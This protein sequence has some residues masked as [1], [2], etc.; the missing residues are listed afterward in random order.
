MASSSTTKKKSSAASKRKVAAK[1]KTNSK[2]KATTSAKAKKN[3]TLPLVSRKRKKPPVEVPVPV[4]PSDWPVSS[5]PPSFPPDASALRPGSL[6]QQTCSGNDIQLA[7]SAVVVP[8]FEKQKGKFLL[9]FPGNFSFGGATDEGVAE[10]QSNAE[11]DGKP[12][13][14]EVKQEDVM[15]AATAN[16]KPAS[17]FTTMGRIEGL[18][19]NT[20]SFRVQFPHLKKSLVFQGKKLSTTSKFLALSCSNKKSGTVQC[21]VRVCNLCVCVRVCVYVC[22]FLIV[23]AFAC[24]D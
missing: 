16:K 9:I 15:A 22:I 18:R 6:L 10:T 5:H 3:S 24:D 4:L 1:R 11:T 23:C 13:A 14:K 2:P 17:A 21:K 20:P 12:L 19:T 8:N 7:R